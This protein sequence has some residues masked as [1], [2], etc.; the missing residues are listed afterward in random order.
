MTLVGT[1]VL[2]TSDRE[3][4]AELGDVLLEFDENGSLTYVV[5]TNDRDQ[6][7]KLRYVIDEDVIVTDQPSAPS[8][9]RTSFSLC[10]DDVLTLAF[11]GTPYRFIRWRP[12]PSECLEAARVGSSDHE[13]NSG[14]T[15]LIS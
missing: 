9:E 15:I 6:I 8:V 4:I 3:A 1:W 11:G 14:D 2:D 12:R 13:S 5:R 7:V 10:D